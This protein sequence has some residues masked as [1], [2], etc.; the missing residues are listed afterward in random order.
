MAKSFESLVE[1]FGFMKQMLKNYCRF[2]GED[3]SGCFKQMGLEVEQT[4][5][6]SICRLG[7]LWYRP[8]QGQLAMEISVRQ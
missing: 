5:E 3:H 8:E 1:A 4:T 6:Q 7:L 2:T